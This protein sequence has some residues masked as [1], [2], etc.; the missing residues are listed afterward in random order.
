M[1]LL[2]QIYPTL[3]KF[4]L[5]NSLGNKTK[6]STNKIKWKFIIKQKQIEKNKNS[7]KYVLK[8]INELEKNKKINIENITNKK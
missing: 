4:H 7:E 2:L 3:G 1:K 8:K 6:T 5:A